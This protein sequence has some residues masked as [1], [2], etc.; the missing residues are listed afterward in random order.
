MDFY[1]KQKQLFYIR[2]F[3]NYNKEFKLC[4]KRERIRQSPNEIAE[5]QQEMMMYGKFVEMINNIKNYY[6]NNFIYVERFE[7]GVLNYNLFFDV[8]TLKTRCNYMIF[9]KYDKELYYY[10]LNSYNKIKKFMN[11]NGINKVIDFDNFCQ[12]LI[13]FP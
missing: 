9:K 1:S 10:Y 12:F 13:N 6:K 5:L 2:N 4:K 11:D 7:Y 3:N 8:I